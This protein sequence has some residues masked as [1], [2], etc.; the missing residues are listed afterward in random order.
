MEI[1]FGLIITALFVVIFVQLN[2]LNY[3]RRKT[4]EHLRWVNEEI[5]AI[6]SRSTGQTELEVAPEAA[7]QVAT[8]HDGLALKQVESEPTIEESPNIMPEEQIAATISN[9]TETPTPEVETASPIRETDIDKAISWV[10]EFLFGGNLIVRVGV[11]VL[12]FGAVFLVKYA[13]DHAYFPIALRLA[14]GVV[15]AMALI[16]VGWYIREKRKGYAL[17]LQAGGIGIIYL[18]TYA[19]FQYYQFIPQSAAFF[20]L[21]FLTT[22]SALFAVLQDSKSLAVLSILAGFAAPILLSTGEGNHVVLFGYYS[23][24]NLGVLLIAWFKQ[25]RILNLLAF[26]F[27]FGIG[28][29]W[30][31]SRYYSEFFQT[32]EPFLIIFFLQFNA[33]AI[34]FAR[35][36]TTK[37]ANYV[38]GTLVFGTPLIAFSL[39]AALVENFEYG[40]AF[41]C[42]ALGLFYLTTATL[43]WSRSQA[44]KLL[45]ES[46]LA[47]GII[48]TTLIFPFI[49]EGE[50]TAA[51]WALE[52]IGLVW[53]GCR[54]NRLFARLFGQ[55]LPFISLL[56]VLVDPTPTANW[57]FINAYFLTFASIAIASFA[58]SYFY[59]K[60]NDQ[61]PSWERWLT[62]PHLIFAGLVWFLAGIFDIY[63]WHGDEEYALLNMS[64]P[65]YTTNMLLSFPFLILMFALFTQVM[66]TIL[67]RKTQ[68]RTLRFSSFIYALSLIYCCVETFID[69]GQSISEIMFFAPLIGFAGYYFMLHQREKL[70]YSFL[71]TPF[72]Q[73]Y[74]LVVFSLYSAWLFAEYVTSPGWQEVGIGITFSIGLMLSFKAKFWPFS[75]YHHAYA[76]WTAMT[77]MLGLVGWS[78]LANFPD[79]NHLAL[80]PYYPLLNPFDLV[81]IFVLL[82]MFSW[83][84][85]IKHSQTQF[86]SGY[87]LILTTIL[88]LTFITIN[89]ILLRTLHHWYDIDYAFNAL[90]QSSLV[91]VTLSVFWAVVSLAIMIIAT[92]VG[93]R[94]AWIVGASLLAAVVLKLFS[95]D[96]GNIETI[97]RIISFIVVGVLILVVGFFSPLPPKNTNQLKGST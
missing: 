12:F 88:M 67:E 52:G 60:H 9:Q 68:W 49:L 85:Y 51:I 56:I 44:Q 42:L 21:I 32:T 10:K 17:A 74:G 5:D 33:M 91:Q 94:V 39:Q 1:I 14:A 30:G 71:A 18:I 11:I 3:H 97:A 76:T 16:S 46:Y 45:A 72:L 4:L 22:I 75:Q 36:N 69:Y 70:P 6:K 31:V 15:G 26:F 13:A 8:D 95:I 80:I 59:F 86:V 90:Y 89:V 40:M 53:I 62:Y 84:H 65:N 35:E 19:S 66:L 41:T 7:Q 54:Q 64:D 93:Q 63:D 38:D 27:T 81:Q 96:L 50:Q 28:T 25:W 92:R 78:F 82:T 43:L 48:F 23:I 29:M 73:G 79:S 61:L 34:L 57:L 2:T 24:L 87:A 20:V 47:L 83:S 37:F 58:I 77:F 55:I